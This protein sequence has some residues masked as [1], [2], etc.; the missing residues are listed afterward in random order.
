MIEQQQY[1]NSKPVESGVSK[2]REGEIF[3]LNGKNY[4]LVDDVVHEVDLEPTQTAEL[5]PYSDPV[6]S[7]NDKLKIVIEY[8]GSV[9]GARGILSSAQSNLSDQLGRPPT[10]QSF[11]DPDDGIRVISLSGLSSSPTDSPTEQS[12]TEKNPAPAAS[13]PPPA[14]P[15]SK[16]VTLPIERHIRH[17]DRSRKSLVVGSYAL[18]ALIVGGIAFSANGTAGGNA[19][20][21]HGLP[22]LNVITVAGC[23]TTGYLGHFGI[24]LSPDGK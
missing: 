5:L 4:V 17:V 24:N 23:V 7:K 6:G 18:A 12:Y 3:M 13:I 21:A 1:D 14:E 16:E 15:V 11:I 9:A 20:A 19:C 10:H 22:N 2:P 8:R